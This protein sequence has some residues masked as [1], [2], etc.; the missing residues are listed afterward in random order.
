MIWDFYSKGFDRAIFGSEKYN[1]NFDMSFAV[2]EIDHI[3]SE[4]NI[5][6]SL[7]NDD[8]VT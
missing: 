8:Y 3:D 7:E 2:Y 5:C 6:E 4:N 1:G